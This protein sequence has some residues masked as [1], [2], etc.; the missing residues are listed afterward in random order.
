MDDLKVSH[1]DSKVVDD[2]LTWV[3][4]KYGAVGEVKITR[5]KID[6]YLGMILDYSVQGQVS[7]DMTEYVQEMLN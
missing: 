6:K 3:K 7:I 4:E 5:G 2:F 1:M